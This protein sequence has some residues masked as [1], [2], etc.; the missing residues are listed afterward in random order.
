MSLRFPLL[1]RCRQLYA[2]FST[3]PHA[4]LWYFQGVPIVPPNFH[5]PNLDSAT[6]LTLAFYFSHLS[7]AAF[8][9]SNLSTVSLLSSTGVRS[10]AHAQSAVHYPQVSLFRCA[11]HFPTTSQ[12]ANRLQ[13]SLSYQSF[14]FIFQGSFSFSIYIIS[15]FFNFFKFYFIVILIF[16]VAEVRFA[17]TTFCLWGRRATTATTPRY[18]STYFACLFIIVSSKPLVLPHIITPLSLWAKIPYVY[19]YAGGS[20]VVIRAFFLTW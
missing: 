20:L 19:S 2:D 17:L 8:T 15:Q 7:T 4:R 5:W 6:L 9:C 10:F 11:E 16:V 1:G 12:P 14:V 3:S 18:K 13:S